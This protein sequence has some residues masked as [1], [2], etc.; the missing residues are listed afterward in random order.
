M[1]IGNFTLR[2]GG[3]YQGHVTVLGLVQEAFLVPAEPSRKGPDYRVMV[4][5]A[6]GA[7][8]A[9]EAGAAWKRHSSKTGK[10]YLSVKL[11][12]PF[13]PVPVNCALIEPQHEDGEFALVWSRKKPAAEVAATE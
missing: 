5:D 7:V 13:L 9:I 4:A 8:G 6:E 12:S 11:D 1:I 10:D 3:S 2:A